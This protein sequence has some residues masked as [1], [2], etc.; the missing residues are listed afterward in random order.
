MNAPESVT[1][2]FVPA[3]VQVVV[4]SSPAGLSFTVDST[5]YTSTQTLTWNVGS[6]HTISTPS[7]QAGAPGTQSVFN[8]CVRSVEGAR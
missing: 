2:N 1:A 3:T 6:S 7:P 5:T 4:G 8:Y